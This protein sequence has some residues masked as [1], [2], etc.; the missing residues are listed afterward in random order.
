MNKEDYKIIDN[1]LWISK[2]ELNRLLKENLKH[3]NESLDWL[4]KKNWMHVGA[5]Y[6]WF[7]P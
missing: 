6:I 5:E 7:N 1:G 2:K 4:I 3:R